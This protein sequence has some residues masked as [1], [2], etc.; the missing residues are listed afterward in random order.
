MEQCKALDA[1]ADLRVVPH[2]HV[3][4]RQ[5]PGGAAQVEPGVESAWF[6]LLKLRFDEPLS[7]FAFNFDVLCPYDLA[8]HLN[9]DMD[10]WVGG[11][12]IALYI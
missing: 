6:Q 10:S 5:R 3:L 7:K 8:K 11:R 1:G 12:R 9:P 4:I 2:R